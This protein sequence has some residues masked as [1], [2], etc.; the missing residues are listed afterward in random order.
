MTSLVTVQVSMVSSISVSLRHLALLLQVP[1]AVVSFSLLSHF[2]VSV[3]SM[4]FFSCR[5]DCPRLSRGSPLFSS[6]SPSSSR[7]PS[8]S[9]GHIG[10]GITIIPHCAAGPPTPTASG[11]HTQARYGAARDTVVVRVIQNK[12]SVHE[13]GWPRCR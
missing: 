2:A 6:S 5:P 9:L 13:S 12:L 10:A 3:S 8:A 4:N 1:P 7:L 11:E